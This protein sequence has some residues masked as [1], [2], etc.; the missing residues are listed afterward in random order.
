MVRLGNGVADARG[1]RFWARLY[2]NAGRGVAG[3]AEH[4][5]RLVGASARPRGAGW[6]VLGPKRLKRAHIALRKGTGPG[7]A[8]S[9]SYR[10]QTR[11]RRTKIWAVFFKCAPWTVDNGVDRQSAL[12]TRKANPRASGRR[13]GPFWGTPPAELYSK[14]SETFLRRA[15]KIDF[16]DF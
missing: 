3:H 11:Q 12:G 13:A 2:V 6:T 16:R 15:A 9:A 1:S 14:P 8:R 5:D 4:T 7:R 10:L